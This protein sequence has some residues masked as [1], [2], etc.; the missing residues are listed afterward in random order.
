MSG[1]VILFAVELHHRSPRRQRQPIVRRRRTHPTLHHRRHIHRHIRASL[2]HRNHLRRAPQRR[3]RR[4]RHAVLTPTPPH[5]LHTYQPRRIHPVA[6]QP[7]SRSRHL[8]RRR[9]RRQRREVKLQQRRIPA[10]NIQIGN[11][12]TIHRRQRAVHMSVRH[13][14]RLD[15]KRRQSCSPQRRQ[16]HP[17]Q[18]SPTN[19]AHQPLKDSPRHANPRIQSAYPK[20]SPNLQRS[21]LCGA[22]CRRSLRPNPA[23]FHICGKQLGALPF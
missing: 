5:R 9:P 15:R 6:I 3:Q 10:A 4:I 8:R 14:R 2:T 18:K 17:K 19:L 7:Q 21:K 20:T 16:P 22:R 1:K 23:I 12:P 11:R 13:Q